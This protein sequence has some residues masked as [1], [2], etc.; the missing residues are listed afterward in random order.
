MAVGGAAEPGALFAST[1]R[2]RLAR[3]FTSPDVSYLLYEV[4]GGSFIASRWE[5]SAEPVRVGSLVKP[6]TA[7]AYAEGHQFRFPVHECHGATSCWFPR[8]HGRIGI[9]RAVAVSCNSYFAALG[10]EAGAAEVRASARRFGLRGPELNASAEALTGKSGLWRES[11]DAMVRAY[12]MLLERR[13]QPGIREIVSGMAESARSGT[14][15]A[16]ASQRLHESLLAKTGTAP[17]THKEHSP[18]DGFAIVAWPS[19]SP[20]YVLMV[21]Q[22][23]VPGA[24]ASLLAGRMLHDLEP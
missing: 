1:A 24:Q 14:A 7:L 5:K 22:H 12:A 13:S 21:R 10:A 15:S 17:C 19:D 9:V 2:E 20:R 18:G 11:P 16:I 4:R 23:G 3:D 6:F 8:G